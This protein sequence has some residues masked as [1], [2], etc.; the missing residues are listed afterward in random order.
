VAET[1]LSGN[2]YIRYY[3]YTAALFKLYLVTAHYNKY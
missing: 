3:Y 2:Y 1:F